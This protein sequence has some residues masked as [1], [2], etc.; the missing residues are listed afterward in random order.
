MAQKTLTDYM[1]DWLSGLING[2][3]RVISGEVGQSRNQIVSVS[4]DTLPV[5]ATS[6]VAWWDS[7]GVKG[8]VISGVRVVSGTVPLTNENWRV[9]YS[10]NAPNDAVD[11]AW[12]PVVTPPAAAGVDIGPVG[13]FDVTPI[14][15]PHTVDASRIMQIIL[16]NP[17]EIPV[18]TPIT[19]LG[20]AHN[21][22]TDVV[23][24]FIINAVEVA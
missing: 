13:G 23:L 15:V 11:G 21:I 24:E 2:A 4:A 18:S 19:R 8:I 16:P 17:V 14:V 9:R 6:G 10:I 5:L 20:L 22:G 1:M 12:L 7:P 3:A